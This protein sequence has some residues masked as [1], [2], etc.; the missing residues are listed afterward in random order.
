VNKEELEILK[1]EIITK[2]L[3]PM[4]DRLLDFMNELKKS[5]SYEEICS[6]V[7]KTTNERRKEDS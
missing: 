2:Q 4:I 3:F 7:E 5:K 1:Q 6:L